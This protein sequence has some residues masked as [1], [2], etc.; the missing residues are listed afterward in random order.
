VRPAKVV[1]PVVE[2]E[3]VYVAPEP[4]PVPAKA[5]KKAVMFDDSENEMDQSYKPPAKAA[6]V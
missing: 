5:A 3:P 6:K 1:E 2:P 4:K